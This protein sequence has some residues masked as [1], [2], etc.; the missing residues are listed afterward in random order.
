MSEKQ[1]FNALIEF[2]E[3]D[4][5]DFQ[6]IEGLSTLS[7]GFSGING[8]WICYAQAR[9]SQ[10]Q[11]IFYSVLPVNVPDD[12]RPNMAEFITR[13]NYGM[14][15]GNFELDYEDGEV[16]YKTSVDVEGTDLSMSLIRQL[17]YANLVVTDRYLPGVMKVMYGDITP[18]A[19]M[20][21]VE[22]LD[23]DF[24][25]RLELA[26][27]DEDEF[28]FEDDLDDFFEDDFDFGDD[29]ED[30]DLDDDEDDLSNG[31]SSNGTG[32]H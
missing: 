7:M 32:R 29:D 3:E 22:S 5:W 25:E 23:N 18:L 24:I 26:E 20:E 21:Y 10:H 31:L 2:F 14:I 30:D 16:R 1:I 17:V 9:E 15:I 8:K 27:D 6:W 11:F 19:A 12:K 28:D 13:V 4:E